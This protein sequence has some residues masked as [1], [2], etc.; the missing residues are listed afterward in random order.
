MQDVN[1][2]SVR[3]SRVKDRLQ[4]TMRDR[5]LNYGD[6]FH[7]GQNWTTKGHDGSFANSDQRPGMDLRKKFKNRKG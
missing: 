1:E 2:S 6:R 3:A 4:S 7:F 5:N